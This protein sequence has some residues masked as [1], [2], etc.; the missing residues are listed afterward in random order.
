MTTIQFIHSFLHIGDLV[1]G[2][3]SLLKGASCVT[4]LEMEL[5]FDEFVGRRSCLLV[6]LPG[7]L[8]NLLGKG[9]D[10]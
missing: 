7:M 5:H 6:R 2:K 3:G 8:M 10:F 1:R 4:C 9:V